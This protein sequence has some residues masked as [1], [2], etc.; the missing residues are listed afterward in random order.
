MADCKYS[1]SL[2]QCN[3]IL[4][5]RINNYKQLPPKKAHT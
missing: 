5:D 3:R 2:L 1:V 4:L